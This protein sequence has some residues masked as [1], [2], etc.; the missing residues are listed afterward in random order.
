MPRLPE[1]EFKCFD[2]V[3]VGKGPGCPVSPLP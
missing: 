1:E 2:F 3:M